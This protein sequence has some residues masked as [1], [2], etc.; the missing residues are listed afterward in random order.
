[1]KRHSALLPL[2][3][4]LTSCIPNQQYRV[5][6]P[7]LRE[8]PPAYCPAA[9][10]QF[11]LSFIEFDDMGELWSAK[12]LDSAIAAIKSAKGKA[13]LV[14]IFIHGWK[15]NASDQSGNVWGFRCEL[16][17]IAYELNPLG[18]PVIGVYLGW[19]GDIVRGDTLKNL[20]FANRMTAAAR[21]PGAHMTGAITQIMRETK[22]SDGKGDA[23]LIVVGHSFGGLVL[24]RAVTQ[25]LVE[26]IAQAGEGGDGIQFPADLVVCLNEA[27]PALEAKQLLDLL[28]REHLGF[29]TR[30]GEQHPLLLS[31]TSEGDTATHLAFPGG[32]AL[33]LLKVDLRKYDPPGDEFGITDQTSY[34]LHTTANTEAL[35]SHVIAPTPNPTVDCT[36]PGVYTCA[37]IPGGK[38]YTVSQK[39]G[40]KN[41]TPYWAMQMPVE[42]VPDHTN[43]FRPEFDALLYAFLNKRPDMMKKMAP[44]LRATPTVTPEAPALRP[45]P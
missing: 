6:N 32:Q 44:Q 8:T 9:N 33:S 45:K 13:P 24:E 35:Q 1:M 18:R 7:V 11:T 27:G 28:W 42:F 5:A 21:I 29:S 40:A 12:E 38:T 14:L 39:A 4:G 31:M 10:G 37:T 16:G 15:N 34:Y 23:T 30:G 3:V 25:A 43:I 19:R 36:K 20:T 17:R 26:R 22:G 41:T 2:I